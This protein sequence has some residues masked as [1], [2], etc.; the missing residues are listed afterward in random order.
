MFPGLVALS[1]CSSQF[2]SG[3][4]MIFELDVRHEAGRFAMLADIREQ[5]S[6]MGS[7][8]DVQGKGDWRE[9]GERAMATYP[10]VRQQ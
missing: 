2:M 4:S 3:K 6:D 5:K 9:Y 10:K 1:E 8:A 7:L